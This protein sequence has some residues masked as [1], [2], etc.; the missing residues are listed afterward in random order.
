[1]TSEE[2]WLHAM[3]CSVDQLFSYVS[4]HRVCKS[5]V[6]NPVHSDTVSTTGSL[7]RSYPAILNTL[8]LLE[9]IKRDKP[10]NTLRDW[11]RTIKTER[12]RHRQVSPQT[13]TVHTFPWNY[14][15]EKWELWKKMLWTISVR[16][17]YEI[18]ANDNDYETCNN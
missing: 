4:A 16:H 17:I 8:F 11:I 3:F 5:Q 14:S 18:N 15:L 10:A 9:D 13:H 7:S 12:R 1:M 2:T 6:S